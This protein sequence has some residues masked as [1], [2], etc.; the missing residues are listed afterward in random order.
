MFPASSHYST[1]TKESVETVL[2]LYY[3]LVD[4]SCLLSLQ[5]RHERKC[6]DSPASLLFISKYFL[7][8][9]TTVPARKK[10]CWDNPA[11]WLSFLLSLQYRHQRKVLRQFYCFFIIYCWCFFPP[12]TTVPALKK[13]CWDSS[14]FLLLLICT[15]RHNWLIFSS[16]EHVETA[17]EGINTTEK[18]T[19]NV[20]YDQLFPSTVGTP[21]R[22][23][24]W[25]GANAM[26]DGPVQHGWLAGL[27]GMLA[28][29]GKH[30]A[31]PLPLA[32]PSPP[33]RALWRSCRP[34]NHSVENWSLL[35]EGPS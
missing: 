14:A 1:G 26:D 34:V 7:P 19:K 4:V 3:L 25:P 28:R 35:Q 31:P 9:L 27:L 2:L 6:W 5:Y 18:K 30:R 29:H 23:W 15:V 33:P 22:P 11:S 32:L 21:G 16:H 24:C 10:K 8:P 20:L 12:L 13:K 17:G